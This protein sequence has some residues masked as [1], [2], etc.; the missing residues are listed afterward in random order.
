MKDLI[1]IKQLPVIEEQLKKVSNE[2]D[3]KI[4][5]ANSLVCTEET[6]KKVKEIR[7]DLN[8]EF[9]EFESKRKEVK[10]KI[11]A[12]YEQFES[13]YKECISDKF[14]KADIDLKNKVTSVENELKEKKEQ[15]I[16]EYFE[17]YKNANKVDFVKYEQARINVTLTA[18]MK[19]LKEQAKDFIDKR[20]NDLQLIELQ[21]H[22][23]EILVE[24]KQSLDVSKSITTVLN[25]KEQ[26]KKEIEI[27]ERQ[28]QERKKLEENL[29]QFEEAKSNKVLEAPKVENI[30]QKI[31]TLRFTVRGSREKLKALKEFLE[32][33]GYDYE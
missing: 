32:E 30:K 21:E 3:E 5:N 33:G 1:I 11:L 6:V 10:E 20:I 9:K 19:S 22:K 2:I 13:I 4:E 12:P 29:A 26:I 23:E 8:K 15:E 31:L 18:S 16:I 14:K 25:R 7:A 17:E 28:E 27:K 24:Y